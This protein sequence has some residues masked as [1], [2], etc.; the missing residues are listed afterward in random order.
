MGDTPLTVRTTR[1]PAVQTNESSYKY[2]LSRP[3]CLC[4][5]DELLD[6]SK[7]SSRTL[8]TSNHNSSGRRILRKTKIFVFLES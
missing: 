2:Y 1:V 6:P 7:L 3:L 4:L 5:F 8:W